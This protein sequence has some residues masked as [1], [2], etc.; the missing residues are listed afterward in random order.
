MIPGGLDAEDV[1][2]RLLSPP[3]NDW[4]AEGGAKG[5]SM[6]G[7]EKR[8]TGGQSSDYGYDRL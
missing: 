5:S 4:R 2:R 3:G 1:E 8:E 7:S 6:L